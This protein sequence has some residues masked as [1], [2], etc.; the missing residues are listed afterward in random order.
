MKRCL[1]VRVH[2]LKKLQDT[3]L[4]PRELFFSSLTGDTVS[5]SDYA[6]VN[7]W[8]R[9]S[10]RTLGEYSDLC[11]KTDVLLLADI[12]ENF[13]NSCAASYGL[14]PAHYT[15][16]GIMWAMLKHTRVRFELHTDIDMV[17]AVYTAVSVNVPA[18]TRR[19]ITSTYIRSIH[20]NCC[21][22][23]C[24]TMWIICTDGW[25]VNLCL[26]I[27]MGR[28]CCKLWRERAGFT[29][30]LY[31]ADILCRSISS[32]RSI[33]MTNTLA[34]CPISEKTANGKVNF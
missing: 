28:R 24:T 34:F 1:S 12:F 22:T 32:I 3:R 2:W 6:D 10:I 4:L 26:C 13:C 20:Q 9:F 14:D 33:Y 15:L 11:L 5:K 8:Q 30:W 27:S 23:W 21:R 29:Y 18:D 31:C 19:L 7:V 17:I 25:C 16:P